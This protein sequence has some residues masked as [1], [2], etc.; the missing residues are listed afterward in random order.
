MTPRRFTFLIVA[1]IALALTAGAGAFSQDDSTYYETFLDPSGL[2][3][4]LT[5]TALD[6]QGG[7]RLATNGAPAFSTWNTDSDF[8]NGVTYQSILFGP[9][10]LSTLQTSGAGAAA[11]LTLPS[12]LLPL[13]PDIADPV[14]S[15][16]ASTVGDG[17]NVDDPTLVKVG[18]TY[19]MWYTGTAEDG[20]APAIFLATSTDG[21]TWTRAKGNAAVMQGT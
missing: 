3:L 17:D 7:L 21:V 11:A 4:P 13:T 14:L 2:Q 15:P 9:V 5:N 8:A 10:G 16:T 18:S 12:T 20:S 6:A 19:G 1:L